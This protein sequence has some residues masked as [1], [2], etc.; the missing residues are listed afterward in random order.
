MDL[1]IAPV[2]ASAL[3]RG[4][5]VVALETT[6]FAHGLPY[7]RNI[8]TW[9]LL[10]RT[11]SDGGAVPAT[12]GILDGCVHVGL[13][14][15]RIERLARGGREILKVSRRDLAFAATRGR[16]GGTTVAATMI[17]ARMAGI[18]VVSTGGIGGVHRGAETTMDI[19]ADLEEL[20][21]TRIAVV[22]AGAKAILDLPKTLEYLETRGVP[23]VGY[24]TDA[25][26]GFFIRDS[27]LD[28]PL[29]LD[30][31]EEAAELI[32]AHWSLPGAGGIVIANPAPVDSA[33]G[34]N[35]AEA[36]IAQALKEAARE[37]V[38]GK[39]LTPFLLD[40]LAEITGGDSL[41]ANIDLLRNNAALG[42]RIA[43]SYAERVRGGT[44]AS[45]SASAR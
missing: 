33:L 41:D 18:P 12:I 43:R 28:A 44:T 42:A 40:R 39:P 15:D 21:A 3:D 22:C 11:V 35:V 1:V 2:I 26:P 14:R 23:V 29:R 27:G 45:D 10:E 8:E 30:T 7:P 31:P 17:C 38:A 5:P 16:D 32:D 6:L 19:S 4:E 36:A 37:N 34:R 25:F 20:A 24:G 9:E 13:S